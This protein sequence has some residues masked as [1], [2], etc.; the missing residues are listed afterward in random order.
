VIIAAIYLRTEETT[1]AIAS[2]ASVFV[3]AASRSL[4]IASRDFKKGHR[5]VR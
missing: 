1:I 3:S 2:R 4:P 5:R